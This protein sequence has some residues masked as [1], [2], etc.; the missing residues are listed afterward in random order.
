L[1][2]GK[3]EDKEGYKTILLSWVLRN[4]DFKESC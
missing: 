3:S 2:N 1:E 4:W